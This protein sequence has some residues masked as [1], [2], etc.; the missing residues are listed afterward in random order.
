MD[1]PGWLRT[2]VPVTGADP[3]VT[4]QLDLITRGSADVDTWLKLVLPRACPAHLA[5]TAGEHLG[6]DIPV[7]EAGTGV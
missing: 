4:S 2:L 3:D 1:L 5:Q 6:L 7:D